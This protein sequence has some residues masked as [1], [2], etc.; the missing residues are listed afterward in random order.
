[1]KGPDFNRRIIDHNRRLY[2]AYDTAEGRANNVY[3]ISFLGVVSPDNMAD[4]VHPKMPQGHD[5]MGPWLAGILAH[6]ISEGKI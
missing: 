2:A 5:Q 4:Y 6:L 3:V 1:V